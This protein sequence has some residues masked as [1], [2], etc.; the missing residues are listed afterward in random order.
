MSNW[1][2]FFRKA[3]QDIK[4]K[5]MRK[6]TQ[7]KPRFLKVEDFS[8]TLTYADIAYAINEFKKINSMSIENEIKQLRLSAIEI[9]NSKT[10]SVDTESKLNSAHKFEL[11]ADL[12]ESGMSVYNIR[13]Y[14][15]HGYVNFNYWLD[16]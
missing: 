12:L 10:N 9:R 6:N 11:A 13:R 8:G 1:A 14:M 5:Q 2:K 4:D 3:L 7:N 15:L 16:K